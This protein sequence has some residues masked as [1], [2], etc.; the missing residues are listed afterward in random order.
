MHKI[1]LQIYWYHAIVIFSLY[2]FLMIIIAFFGGA[3]M[4]SM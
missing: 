4:G 2:S 3:A 1:A